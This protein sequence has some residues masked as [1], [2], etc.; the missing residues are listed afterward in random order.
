MAREAIYKEM[1]KMF[2]VVPSFIK[3]IPDSVLEP[4]W[5]LFKT[6]QLTE[7]PIPSKYRALIGLGV[8]AAARCRY[9]ELFFRE[10]A[11]VNGATPGEIEH[12]VHSAAAASALSTYVN[13]L[14]I[15]YDQFRKELES[16]SRHV[17]AV[18]TGE[19]KVA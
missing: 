17:R 10:V 16:A 11:M 12:A 6:L 3:G 14:R 19:K 4:E 8:A 9:T 13:G 5:N 7:G 1:E 18:K 15:D 2:G